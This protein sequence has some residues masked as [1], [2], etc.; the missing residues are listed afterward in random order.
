MEKI[1]FSEEEMKLC[2]K[3]SEEV[4]TTLYARRNQFDNEKRKKD[5]KIGK[6]GEFAVVHFLKKKVKDI[7][8]PD[9]E[10][11]S[12]KQ[13]SWDYDLKS[14]KF[15]IHVKTQDITQAYKYGESWIFQNEDKHIF[16][17]YDK[18]K[19]YVAFVI[20]NLITKEAQIKGICKLQLLH[21]NNLFALPKLIH[22]QGNKRAVYMS[23][24]ENHKDLLFQL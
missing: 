14:S 15:N 12:A 5:A 9:C 17:E 11:Y 16:R 23:D 3:F 19:D 8:P 21:D 2:E 22:L 6:L 24:L 20:V 10:I 18:E 13:K 4:D 7:S 1:K